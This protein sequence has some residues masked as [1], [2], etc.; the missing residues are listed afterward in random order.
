MTPRAAAPRTF[1]CPPAPER[2]AAATTAMAR[3]LL[4][5]GGLG[6]LHGDERVPASAHAPEIVVAAEFVVEELGKL[7]D[8]GVYESLTLSRIVQ[9]LTQRGAFHDNTF[10]TL[11]LASPHFASGNATERFECMEMKRF[12]D[13][14]KSF[15]IDAFPHMTD[16]SIEE[17]GVRNIERRRLARQRAFADLELDACGAG[18]CADDA[19]A[20]YLERSS[21]DLL[22]ELKD[23]AHHPNRRERAQDALERRAKEDRLKH[24]VD[25]HARSSFELDAI[26]S[27]EADF[28]VRRALAKRLLDERLALGDAAG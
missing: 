24:L 12:D 10:L 4:L 7:S 22:G 14:A 8:S 18:L 3:W 25:L 27:N 23:A 20:S 5:L 28:A 9:A 13:A 2:A 17:F 21:L 16:A 11:D 6:T 15:A 1:G 26:A 19:A